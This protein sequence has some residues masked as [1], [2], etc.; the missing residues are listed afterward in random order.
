MYTYLNAI[1][2]TDVERYGIPAIYYY[3]EYKGYTMI[4]LTLLNFGFNA[5]FQSFQFNII[6]ILVA[7]RE[8]VSKI[9]S[10][11]VLAQC[12]GANVHYFSSLKFAQGT[13]YEIEAKSQ[14]KNIPVISAIK[15]RFEK[16][17]Q[18]YI[19]TETEQTKMK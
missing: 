10:W 13:N 14:M 15:D 17:I 6:D 18:N 4:G 12:N 3:G 19:L 11:S 2:N 9:V 16:Y 7:F 5:S 1:N 8:F